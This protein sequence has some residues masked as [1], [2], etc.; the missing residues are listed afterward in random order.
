MIKNLLIGLLVAGLL[1]AGCGGE[2]Y[3]LS[4]DSKITEQDVKLLKKSYEDMDSNERARLITMQKDMTDKEREVFK[5]D[6]RRL[7]L[8]E[9]EGVYTST[10]RAKE[11]FEKSWDY[12]T[13]KR[14]G[15]LTEGE[16]EQEE[17]MKEKTEQ[18]IA[19]SGIKSSIQSIIDNAEYKNTL[20]D[21]IVINENL[22]TDTQGDY[23][24]LI[25]LV[26]DIKNT[27]KTGNEIMRMYSDDLVATMAP[28][29]TTSISEATIF[30]E[31]EYN[32]R[33]VKYAY[34]YKDGGF[35]LTDVMGE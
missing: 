3:K 12:E 9:M 17:K 27:T 16:Q 7:Y 24:A 33:T 30:W 2:E 29:S 28:K 4:E 6:F 14:K 10:E 19:T 15:E 32:N 26:Y 22:G 35:Y 13:R 25:Y 1:L 23:I 34:E 11:A 5:E 8:E 21:K 20:V 31:D 18:T